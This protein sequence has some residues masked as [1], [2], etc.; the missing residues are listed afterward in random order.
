[1]RSATSDAAPSIGQ[2]GARAMHLLKRV[3][4]G[5][6]QVPA[7]SRSNARP[8]SG[9]RGSVVRSRSKSHAM[10]R[11]E[12]H[13]TARACDFGRRLNGVSFTRW[14]SGASAGSASRR[15]TRTR[16]RCAPA[17]SP[18]RRSV[19]SPSRVKASVPA[20]GARGGRNPLC[21]ITAVRP[22]ENLRICFFERICYL[23]TANALGQ[24]PPRRLDRNL[25]SS[26]RHAQLD[27]LHRPTPT[28][29]LFG[30][31]NGPPHLRRCARRPGPV[32]RHSGPRGRL[33]RQPERLLCERHQRLLHDP[34]Q[35]GRKGRDRDRLRA[36]LLG[37]RSRPFR[38]AL[39]RSRRP[40]A[41][42]GLPV[43]QCGHHLRTGRHLLRWLDHLG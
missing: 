5:P 14:T 20:N 25:F 10:Q 6:S 38:D 4:P 37:G 43:L 28:P 26:E 11:I 22:K 41:D 40:R 30:L 23:A 36:R 31:R 18:V 29:L 12:V 33:R 9:Q 8:H 13:R 2:P 35:R 42:H 7:L 24:R 21:L 16:P 39:D 32:L 19:F 34:P 15:A 1:M 27:Q 17:T 3:C